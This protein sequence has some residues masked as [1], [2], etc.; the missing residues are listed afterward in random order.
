MTRDHPALKNRS[1]GFTLVEVM[2]ALGVFA[3]AVVGLITALN[4]AIEAA[5]EVRQRA[6]IRT[7][8]ES[9][10]ALRM[11]IPLDKEKLVITAKDNHGIGIEET[12]VDYPLKNKDGV[13]ISN[14]KKLTIT[15]TLDK[16]SDSASILVSE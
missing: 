13:D 4:T 6:V 10:I 15:A 16:Q 9:R 3:I 11:A 2:L 14:I 1:G 8:L 5:L 7:E 12:I